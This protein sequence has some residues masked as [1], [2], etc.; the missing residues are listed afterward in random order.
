MKM[1]R[2]AIKEYERT[3][4]IAPDSAGVYSNLGVVYYSVNETDKALM[5]FEKALS[6]AKDE[7]SAASL[8][9][10]VGI[11]YLEKGLP[12]KAAFYLEKAAS[13]LH[14]SNLYNFLGIAFA[15]TGQEDKA[16]GAFREA[17]RIDPQNSKALN[18]LDKLKAG[19]VGRGGN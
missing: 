17:L 16:Y 5:M 12:E 15:S 6:F 8:N 19:G 2:E 18:N 1:Y 14:D 11:I 3:L 9:A 13:A 7:N 4:E 10:R